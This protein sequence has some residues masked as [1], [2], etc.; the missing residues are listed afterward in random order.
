MGFAD[1]SIDTDELARPDTVPPCKF[2]AVDRKIA[3]SLTLTLLN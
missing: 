1:S 2:F 3:I